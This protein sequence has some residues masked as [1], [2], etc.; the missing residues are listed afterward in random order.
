MVKEQLAVLPDGSPNVK[1]T[2]VVPTTKKPPDVCDCVSKLTVPEL[3]MAVA[4][5]KSTGVP[6]MLMSMVR[7][8]SLGHSGTGGTLSTGTLIKYFT[9][10]NSERDYY[11][12]DLKDDIAIKWY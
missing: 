6:P 8:I 2:A 4:S 9:N 10:I 7:A 3:S 11:D 1:V 12:F 5:G